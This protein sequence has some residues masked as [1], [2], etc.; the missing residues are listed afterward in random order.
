MTAAE[1]SAF[2]IALVLFAVGT[3]LAPVSCSSPSEF[4][5][6]AVVA[7]ADPSRIQSFDWAGFTLA[8]LFLASNKARTQLQ[9]NGRD[10]HM[11]IDGCAVF[12]ILFYLRCH[13][14]VL[15]SHVREIKVM[16]EQA[17]FDRCRLSSSCRANSGSTE[18]TIVQYCF[19]YVPVLCIPINDCLFLH[20]AI[21][22]SQVNCCKRNQVLS[23][24][25]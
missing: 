3:F 10:C 25:H 9:L 12:L 20:D 22:M 5:R 7:V 11:N 19:F 24:S 14:G 21:D 2:V 4:D 1:E 13:Y 23:C 18:V 17:I 8:S 6:G 16:E 15:P